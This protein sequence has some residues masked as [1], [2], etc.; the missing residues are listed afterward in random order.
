MLDRGR[1]SARYLRQN[2]SMPGARMYLP[3][4]FQGTLVGAQSDGVRAK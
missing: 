3:N 4:S 1:R 2:A